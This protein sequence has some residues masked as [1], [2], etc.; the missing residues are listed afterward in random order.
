GK[1]VWRHISIAQWCFL[2]GALSVLPLAYLKKKGPPRFTKYFQPTVIVGGFLTYAPYNLS[3]YTGGL[4]MS[5]TFMY[6]IKNKYTLWWEKYNYIL[7][8]ALSSGVAFSALVIFFVQFH[9]GELD[10]WG[11]NLS[12]MGIEGQRVKPSWLQA[13]DAPAGYVGLREGTYP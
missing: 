11:N 5:F 6:Y 2:F 13:K 10:W 9:G 4:Y 7:T 12:S 8:S 3:Y 1:S